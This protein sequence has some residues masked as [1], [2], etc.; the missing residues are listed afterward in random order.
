MA[1]QHGF[2]HLGSHRVLGSDVHEYGNPDKP[3]SEL[4]LKSRSGL[5]G[6][7][8]V[9][10]YENT[11]LNTGESQRGAT[12]GSLKGHLSSHLKTSM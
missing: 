10:S 9:H 3:S 4:K 2:Q 7:G 5:N 6:G 11:D 8:S 12:L 1:I